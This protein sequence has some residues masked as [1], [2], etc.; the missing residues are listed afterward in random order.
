MRA[1]AVP[2]DGELWAELEEL[3]KRLEVL[4]RIVLSGRGARDEA[5]RALVP[6]MATSFGSVTFGSRELVAHTRVD[7]KLREAF[8]A[9]DAVTPR[10]VG[11]LLRRLEGQAVGHLRL[12]RCGQDRDG[13]RW[14]VRVCEFGS[15]EGAPA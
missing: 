5:D 8:E 7:P 6:A 14:C 12:E 13:L 9:T 2:R 3:R 10:E 1:I 15:R 11:K 4:E